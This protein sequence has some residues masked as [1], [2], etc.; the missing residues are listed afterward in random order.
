[1]STHPYETHITVACQDARELDRL[2]AWAAGNAAKLTHIVLAR[3]RMPSQPMLT[4]GSSG[5]GLRDH[6]DAAFALERRAREAGFRPVRVKTE[7]VPWAPEAPQED[8]AAA[9]AGA[10]TYFEHH[11]KLALPADFDR[12]RLLAT[13]VPH[14]AHL[15]WNARRLRDPLT[16]RHERFVTQRCHAVGARTAGGRLA[17]LLADIDTD[18]HEVLAVEREFVLVDSDLSVDDGWMAAPASCPAPEEARA[19]GDGGIKEA[20][21]TTG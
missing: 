9:E 19:A 17:A 12:E 18:G 7:T 10:G 2:T 4:L 21:W 20:S 16:G 6:Q 13:A 1:M 5:S 3:G 14:G 11:V 8:E 15:S